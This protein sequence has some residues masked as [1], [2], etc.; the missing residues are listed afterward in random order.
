[1][2]EKISL[3]VIGSGGH[4]HSVID[5]VEQEKNFNIVGL[6]DDFLDPGTQRHG[7]PL[8][9]GLHEL[10]E[11]CMRYRCQSVI[12]AI[13]DN[14]QRSE[15]ASRARVL[16]PL[17]T[18]PSIIHPE[19][20]ISPSASIAA[21][22]IVMPGAIINTGAVVHEG[23]LI[24]TGSI[25]DHDCVLMPYSSVGP[26]AVLGGSVVLGERSSV[27]LGA[28]VIHKISI[29][30]DTVIGAGTT[31]IAN[32]PPLSVSVGSPGR[33]IRSRKIDEKYL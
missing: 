7:Y 27:G 16:H 14:F 19:S 2:T 12:V 23:C 25:V 33:V 24:N 22:M 21:G 6:I 26:G 15:I 3:I 28:R 4:A 11:V 10:S 30:E 32:V 9:G 20:I 17:L 1:M 8:L 18:F 13:G 31:V 29:S 5:T